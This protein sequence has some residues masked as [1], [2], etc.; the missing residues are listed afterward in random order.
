MKKIGTRA[1]IKSLLKDPSVASITP[2]SNFGIKKLINTIDFE[3]TR[4]IVEYGPGGGVITKELLK[5][6]HPDAKLIAIEQN[7]NFANVL[8]TNFDD[9]RLII[10]NDSAE[11]VEEIILQQ[12]NL[13]KIDSKKATHIISGIPFSM[14]PLELKNKILLATQKSI[15]EGGSFLVYQFLVSLSGGKNDI[16]RKMREFFD[17]QRSEVELRNVPPLRIFEGLPKSLT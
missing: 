2:T 8:T 5:R 6:M 13:G 4:L 12:V 17:I 14:F 7:R 11:N 1:Y 3:K 10:V 15:Q 16:K 9:P